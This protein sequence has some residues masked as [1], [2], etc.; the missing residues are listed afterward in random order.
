MAMAVFLGDGLYHFTKIFVMSVR[1]MQTTMRKQKASQ[2][3]PVSSP[4]GVPG[5]AT[6]QQQPEEEPDAKLEIQNESETALLTALRNRVFVSDP[7]PW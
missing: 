6:Q 3:Q 1:S 2:Q 7:V 4:P 5:A